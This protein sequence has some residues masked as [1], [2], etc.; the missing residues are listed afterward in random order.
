MR[1]RST[2]LEGEMVQLKE[3]IFSLQTVQTTH[4]ISNSPTAK[5]RDR[6]CGDSASGET[7]LHCRLR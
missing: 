5:H 2:E 7:C 6:P 3:M 4:Q 1:K